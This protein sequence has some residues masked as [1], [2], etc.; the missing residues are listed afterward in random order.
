MLRELATRLCWDKQLD[1]GF[2]QLEH[3]GYILSAL[4]ARDMGGEMTYLGEAADIT[5]DMCCLSQLLGRNGDAC[6]YQNLRLQ[7]L[8]SQECPLE[9]FVDPKHLDADGDEILVLRDAYSA[10]AALCIENGAEM[11]RE[12]K[13][14]MALACLNSTHDFLRNCSLFSQNH[15][16][17]ANVRRNLAS[18]F[19]DMK[20]TQE[21]DQYD[22]LV[23]LSNNVQDNSGENRP[24]YNFKK[25]FFRPRPGG[26]PTLYLPSGAHIG[27]ADENKVEIEKLA[28][29]LLGLQNGAGAKEKKKTAKKA[30]KTNTEKTKEVRGIPASYSNFVMLRDLAKK[31]CWEKQYMK[32]FYQLEHAVHVLQVINVQHGCADMIHADKAAD[33]LDDMAC[34]MQLM[35][36]YKKAYMY[37]MIRLQTLTGLEDPLLEDFV[38]A[39]GDNLVLSDTHSAMFTI[40][41]LQAER[42]EGE[43]KLS[44]ALEALESA[45]QMLHRCLLISDNHLQIAS[46]RRSIASILRKLKRGAEADVYDKQSVTVNFNVAA[47]KGPYTEKD[48]IFFRPVHGGAPELYMPDDNTQEADEETKKVPD[49]SADGPAAGGVSKKKTEHAFQCMKSLAAMEYIRKKEDSEKAMQALLEEEEED[50]KRA[51]ENVSKK[52]KKK[53]VKTK[54]AKEKKQE[55]ERVV[56]VFFR[57]QKQSAVAKS[58]SE[59]ESLA[60]SLLPLRLSLDPVSP[61]A[62]PAVSLSPDSKESDMDSYFEHFLCPISLEI[63]ED[64]V[65]TVDGSSYERASIE[66]WFQKTDRDPLTNE[67]V[68][69][70]AL[71]P[72]K[73]LKSAIQAA[74]ELRRVLEGG[75]AASGDI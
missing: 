67:I 75:V 59:S 1:R 4:N 17:V 37:L 34:I 24:Y 62:S 57:E 45:L 12:G 19:R 23:I 43:G 46:T 41:K 65:M 2:T 54:Q 53:A 68:T 31:L 6:K 72:N 63:M 22:A 15:V 49:V 9:C 30:P 5:D 32:A 48:K 69:S 7:T 51:A 40:L 70:K 20:R 16:Q 13:F 71:T 28:R 33:V 47:L 58:F 56:E 35:C 29:K 36:D 64:P 26:V 52:T 10:M 61:I 74:R 3:A 50:K 21:A 60:T 14:S 73:A 27:G 38:A 39:D 55:G 11:Q 25:I 42:L 8:T 44:D 66:A 18:V